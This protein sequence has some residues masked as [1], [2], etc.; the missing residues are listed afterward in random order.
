MRVRVFWHN[1]FF[2]ETPLRRLENPKTAEAP[3]FEITYEIEVKLRLL[4]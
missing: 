2:G 1:L 4:A 3:T